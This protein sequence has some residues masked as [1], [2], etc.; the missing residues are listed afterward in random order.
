MVAVHHID[1]QNSDFVGLSDPAFTLT[2]TGNSASCQ[3]ISLVFA[4][5]GREE[6]AEFF[7]VDIISAEPGGVLG[8]PSQATGVI[9]ANGESISCSSNS[10]EYVF[11]SVSEGGGGGEG[12]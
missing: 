8:E 11:S 12:M 7:A 3:D 2:F 5:D 6:C 9:V 4:N 10:N 1:T